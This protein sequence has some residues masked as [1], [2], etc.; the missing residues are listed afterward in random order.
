M[1]CGIMSHYKNLFNAVHL[2]DRSEME[3]AWK[4][5]YRF[6]DVVESIEEL[7]EYEVCEFTMLL[8]KRYYLSTAEI[9]VH[10]NTSTEI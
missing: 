2:S 3:I 1:L 6:Q 4:K 9:V 10:C 8:E 5:L 7:F